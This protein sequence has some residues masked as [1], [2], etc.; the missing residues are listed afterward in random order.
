M[1]YSTLRDVIGLRIEMVI[2]NENEVIDNI[3][4]ILGSSGVV[5]TSSKTS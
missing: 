2:G 4:S 5:T 3:P 1:R